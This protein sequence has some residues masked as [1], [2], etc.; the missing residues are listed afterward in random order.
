MGDRDLPVNSPEDD[1]GNK[2]SNMED[3]EERDQGGLEGLKPRSWVNAVQGKKVL[4]KYDMDIQMMDGIGS[5][6][7]PEEVFT[8]A[9]PLWEDFIIGRFLDKAPDIAKVHAIVNKIWALSYKSQMIDVHV[10]NSTTMKFKVS[11][12]IIRNRILRR[13]MWNIAE[14]PVVMAKWS[15]LT[16]DIKQETHSIPLWIHLKN[17]PMEMY[18]WKGLSFVSSQVGIPV[19]LHPETEQCE[20]LKV[21]KIFVKVDL[22]KQLPKLMNFNLQGKDTLVEYSYPWLPNKCTY[23]GKWGHLARVCRGKRIADKTMEEEELVKTSRGIDSVKDSVE[24]V[25]TVSSE[26][27]DVPVDGLVVGSVV[28]SVDGYVADSVAGSVSGSV[29]GLVNGEVDGLVADS[30][31]GL[32]SGYVVGLVAGVVDSVVGAEKE[33]V[34]GVAGKQVDKLAGSVEREKRSCGKD[35]IKTAVIDKEKVWVEISPGKVSRTPIKSK[36]LEFEQVSMEAD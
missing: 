7:V 29:V 4:K 10:I 28:S 1:R 5:V 36:Q 9:S 25:K 35:N 3:R 14:I 8:D 11:N 26:G 13:S 23:C 30:V 17:V 24:V 6:T 34:T 22:S 20:N 18:S 33:K 27:R 15:L 31:V 32:V 12:P 16:E 21:A 2:G 19:R